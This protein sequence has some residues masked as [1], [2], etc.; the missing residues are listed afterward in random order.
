MTR[1]GLDVGVSQ[2][3]SS[4]PPVVVIASWASPYPYR[5]EVAAA[6]GSGSLL[7]LFPLSRDR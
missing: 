1:V 7:Q 2:S 5:W 3:P 4:T 6:Q